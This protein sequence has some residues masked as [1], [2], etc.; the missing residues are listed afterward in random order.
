MRIKT[1]LVEDNPAD[2]RLIGE[3]LKEGGGRQVVLKHTG[4]LGHG[5]GE[6]RGG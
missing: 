2:A 4:R 1:L 3:M 5:V 6:T